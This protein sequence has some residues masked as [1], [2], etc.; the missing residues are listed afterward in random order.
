MTT[1]LNSHVLTMLGLLPNCTGDDLKS[2]LEGIAPGFLNIF[3]SDASKNEV[4]SM[5]FAG[6]EDKAEIFHPVYK[7]E[8]WSYH[9]ITNDAIEIADVIHIPHQSAELPSTEAEKLTARAWNISGEMVEGPANNERLISNRI[10]VLWRKGQHERFSNDSRNALYSLVHV[11]GNEVVSICK[12]KWWEKWQSTP[13]I[14]LGDTCCIFEK[15]DKTD[16]VI[17]KAAFQEVVI[18]WR[19][20][21]MYRMIER[22]YLKAILQKINQEFMRSPKTIVEDAVRLLDNEYSQF[23]GLVKDHDLCSFFE[24]FATSVDGLSR[25][26]NK[27]AIMLEKEVSEDKLH[28]NSVFAPGNKWKKGVLLCYKARCSI[29]HAGASSLVFDEFPDGD[30]ALRTLVI[31]LENAVM[32]YIGISAG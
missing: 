17:L 15:R 25:G 24:D 3:H 30:D 9:K 18:R 12:E 4:I 29:V 14:N 1:K 26:M 7:I 6:C 22:G 16:L 21:S 13:N 20:L 10:V 31:P 11:V 2:K 5:A 8:K 32:K 19:F 23:V 27:Y 28:K